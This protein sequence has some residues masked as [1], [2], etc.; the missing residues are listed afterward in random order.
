[1]PAPNEITPKQ[2]KRL[3]GTPGC[4]VIV[5]VC[6]SEDFALDPRLVPSAIR[7][8]H[9]ELGSLLAR[10]D[11]RPAV[12]IC[13]KGRKLSQG[14]VSW[15][16]AHGATAEYLQG[17]VLAWRDAGLPLVPVNAVPFDAAGTT[18]WITRARPKIDR[19]ACPWLIRRFID[20]DAKFLFVS[21]SEV[22]SAADQFNAIPFDVEDVHFSHRGDRCTFDAMLEDFGLACK[23]LGRLALAVRAADTNRHDLHPV[24][25]G[26][27]AISVGLSRQYSDD[28]EQ[29][30]AGMALY[31]GLFRWARDG[32][33]E[34]HD[35]PAV[36]G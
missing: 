9:T 3:V 35:W 11:G 31:D 24:A 18:T 17:G 1:M 14:V 28:Q 26:L 15:L 2:L 6:T 12:I 5:D 30:E 36:Q 7:H 13:Q 34:G 29:L 20:R 23:A 19:I 27:L 32:Y 22:H 10:L 4:P 33:N 16:Q 8:S 21:P 25:P